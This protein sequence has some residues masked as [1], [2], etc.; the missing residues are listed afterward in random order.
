M[1][2]MCSFL[3][4]LGIL[5]IA[6]SVNLLVVRLFYN[7]Y[8]EEGS[9]RVVDCLL[10]LIL[11]YLLIPGFGVIFLFRC[12]GR[13][14]TAPMWGEDLHE[15]KFVDAWLLDDMVK[16]SQELQTLIVALVILW[17][18]GFLCSMGC[19]FI[20]TYWKLGEI[21]KASIRSKDP[22]LEAVKERMML[23][24]S[25]RREIAIYVNHHIGSPFIAGLRNVRIYLPQIPESQ[26]AQEL[27]IRHE[28]VHYKRKDILFKNMLLLLQAVH[29]FN[30][31]MG[32]FK[33]YFTEINEL[34]CDEAVLEGKDREQRYEY[35]RLIV[36]MLQQQ[37]RLYSI[38][39]L[40]DYDMKCM[41][42]RLRQVMTC[43][44]K[45][46]RGFTVGAALLCAVSCPL[47]AFAVTRGAV[48][49]EDYVFKKVE[50]ANTVYEE[51]LPFHDNPEIV[52]VMDPASI[53]PTAV[54]IGQRGS[55]SVDCTVSRGKAV[56]AGEAYLTEG[57]KVQFIVASVD[58]SKQ[59]K[60]GIKNSQD[61]VTSVTSSN[62]TVS[63]TFTIRTSGNYSFVIEG[64][65]SGE[66]RVT[67]SIYI[68]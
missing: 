55:N 23:E 39:F 34:A 43:K 28:L 50:E 44:K 24:L 54:K 33:G 47:T 37:S 40:A 29:W 52:S 45:V 4:M 49:A 36:Q 18:I 60:A 17:G 61:K 53:I 32:V 22:G 25:V 19:K 41:E 8:G 14:R 42:R 38:V 58:S 46:Y 26:E 12:V 7:Q 63:H 9:S 68:P 35:G 3:V 64:V 57:T 48:S 5:S 20:Y 16:G 31:F 65:S 27:I 59:F 11:V 67:G 2:Q 30:P 51:M 56:V 62:G 66:Y 21:H 15:Y 6:G 1:E 13:I 10:K